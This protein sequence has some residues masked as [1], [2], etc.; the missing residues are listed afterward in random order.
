[1]DI[2]LNK[3]NRT[4]K[5]FSKK[6]KIKKD[7]SPILINLEIKSVLLLVLLIIKNI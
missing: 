2:L 6:I 1:M 5:S 3:F 4:S 7:Y